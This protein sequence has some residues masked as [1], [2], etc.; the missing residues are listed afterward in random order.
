[1]T[2]KDSS[3][4]SWYLIQCK[5]RQDERAEENLIRQG[6]ECLRLKV[7]QECFRYGRRQT[8]TQSLFP[9]YIFIHMGD[10]ESWAP[11]RSTRGVLRV[12]SFGS[13]PLPIDSDVIAHLQQRATQPNALP[14]L[15]TGE[16]VR[17]TS[18]PFSELE[19]VF[20]GM[21]GDERVVVLLNFLQ[22]KQEVRLPLRSVNKLHG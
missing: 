4:G 6:Y 21:D 8:I 11:L 13:L 10:G 9:G 3:T 2:V 1:M 16:L 5:A 20:L 7:S 22:R 14:A 17:I 15:T 12:V 19:A 18:G